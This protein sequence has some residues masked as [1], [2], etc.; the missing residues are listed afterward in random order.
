MTDRHLQQTVL[1]RFLITLII[2]NTRH[3]ST[4]HELMTVSFYTANLKD[5]GGGKGKQL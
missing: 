3:S 2:T 1:V 4:L 5:G